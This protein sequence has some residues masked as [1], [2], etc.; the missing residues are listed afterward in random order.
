[1]NKKYFERH[2]IMKKTIIFVFAVIFLIGCEKIENSSP[3]MRVESDTNL[4]YNV[5]DMES[6]PFLLKQ[7]E[8]IIIE[9]ISA[10]DVATE[11]ILDVK[12][13]SEEIIDTN[14]YPTVNDFPHG[15]MIHVDDSVYEFIKSEYSKIEWH[16]GFDKGDIVAYEDY[17]QPFKALLDGKSDF[18]IMGIDSKAVEYLSIY[19]FLQ[20]EKEYNPIDTFN[21]EDYRYSLFYF[22]FDG[23]NTP[24]LC[25]NEKAISESIRTTYVFKYFEKSNEIVLL[26]TLSGTN[27]QLMGSNAR[28]KYWEDRWFEF[29]RW[30]QNHD[31][32]YTVKF[33]NEFFYTNGED[34]YLVALPQYMDES[35]VIEIPEEMQK[36]GYYDESRSVYFFHITE[37]Q[38]NELTLEFFK[39]YE[40]AK[41]E[42]AEV[43]YTYSELFEK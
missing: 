13:V 40:N 3:N 14:S 41:L 39:E 16:C 19:E 15:E 42:I 4:S 1:M 35:R 36:Q 28:G 17:K 21:G 31:I 20:I 2:Y 26:T 30:N 33:M 7:F 27:Q 32:I 29:E 43:T 34:N 11:E 10:C 37:E 6:S 18:R 25:I 24:E 38:Y 9:T 23:D 12:Y 8:L 22:D 5:M